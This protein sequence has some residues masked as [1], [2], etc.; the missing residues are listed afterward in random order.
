MT[1]PIDSSP[2]PSISFGSPF[3][4]TPDHTNNTHVHAP[5]AAERSPVKNP[6]RDTP[7]CGSGP[8]GLR[9]LRRAVVVIDDTAGGGG[10][11][12]VVE[13][14]TNAQAAPTV[15]RRT[16]R[17]GFI[18]RLCWVSSS[19]CCCCCC[20]CYCVEEGEGGGCCRLA[21]FDIVYRLSVPAIPRG[22]VSSS[23]HKS[24]D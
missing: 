16:A 3:H 21:G 13:G 6:C 18:L 20:C 14:G 8:F 9:V 24:I 10:G 23:I 1:G 22:L 11:G 2:S 4:T 12:I 5:A 17:H 7:P 19:C 15:N